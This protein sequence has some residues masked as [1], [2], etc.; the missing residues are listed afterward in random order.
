VSDPYHEPAVFENLPDRRTSQVIVFARPAGSLRSNPWQGL[1]QRIPIVLMTDD[2]PARMEL[3]EPAMAAPTDWTLPARSD[4]TVDPRAL[5]GRIV[6]D[7]SGRLYERRG[8][9]IRPLNRFVSR[10]E[11]GPIG[12]TPSTR[13]QAGV[14]DLSSDFEERAEDERPPDDRETQRFESTGTEPHASHR[15]LLHDP[16]VA[17]V[18]RYGEFKEMLHPQLAHPERL[19]DT[20]YLSCYVQVYEASVAQRLEWLATAVLRHPADAS[21]FHPLSIG[22]RL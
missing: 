15:K 17:R 13:T 7:E 19:R 11:Q 18:V 16:G 22:S 2:E 9:W 12:F 3:G 20:H 5:P 1:P 6:C 10:F 8:D 4:I 14:R 21:Q